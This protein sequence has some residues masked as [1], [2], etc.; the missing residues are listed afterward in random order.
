MHT[1]L[2]FLLFLLLISLYPFLSQGQKNKPVRVLIMLDASGSMKEKWQNSTKFSTAKV[3]LRQL[4][5]SLQGEKNIQVALRVFG[6]QSPRELKNCQDSKLEVPFSPSSAQAIF[7]K[8]DEL[9]PQGY[10]PI[11]YSLGLSVNDFLKNSDTK[12]VIILVTD[13]VENCEGDPCETSIKLQAAGIFLKPY[14]IGLGL[15][16]NQKNIFDCVGKVYDIKEEKMAKSVTSVVISN[17][18]NPTTLQVNLINTY[19]NP[20][21]TNLNMTFYNASGKEAEYNIYHTIN[22]SGNPDSLLLDPANIYDLEIHSVPSVKKKGI[23]LLAGKH[24]ITAADV[25]QG[26]LKISMPG[27]MKYKDLKILVRNKNGDIVNI[28]DLN[29]VQQYLTGTYDLEI[30]TTPR[31]NMK[32]VV[33][34]QSKTNTISLAAPGTLNLTMVNPGF[35][36][37][38]T[39]KDEGIE[40]VYSIDASSTKE[41]VQL[42]PGNY[43]LIY[44]PKSA[45]STALTQEKPFKIVSGTVT[46]LKL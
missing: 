41:A 33:I 21:E 25:P 40:R 38:F 9:T 16:S 43:L 32:D 15:S 37:I 4:I 35:T 24:T 3:V 31:I 29:I 19:G 17:V 30:L 27:V 13:G 42:Q 1:A 44:R 34:D 8:L 11:A 36:A 2:K 45:V 23:K 20:T 26:S 12:N 6:H 14:I 18:L 39:V 22:S 5:D 10:T 7:K 28:Q 46:T